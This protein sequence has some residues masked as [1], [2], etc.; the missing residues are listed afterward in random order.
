MLGLDAYIDIQLHLRLM[1]SLVPFSRFSFPLAPV[2]ASFTV[3]VLSDGLVR[4]GRVHCSQPTGSKVKKKQG[5]HH[6]G[7]IPTVDSRLVTWL[8]LNH[9]QQTKRSLCSCVFLLCRCNLYFNTDPGR[10]CWY[11]FSAQ[12]YR[13]P[14]GPCWWATCECKI[15][16]R[17]KRERERE[18]D[19]KSHPASFSP[20]HLLCRSVDKC[21]RT[22]FLYGGMWCAPSE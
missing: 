13:E 16:K 15:N 22:N 11:G 9:V 21:L 5:K 8:F 14:A 18:G 19:R 20:G 3:E 1:V 4:F 2:C 17:K 12:G 7:Q 6:S 10:L